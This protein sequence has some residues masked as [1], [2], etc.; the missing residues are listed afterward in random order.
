MKWGLLSRLALISVLIL[1]APAASLGGEIKYEALHRG[2]GY[3]LLPFDQVRI[4][5]ILTGFPFG[6]SIEINREILYLQE[7]DETVTAQGA[8][9]CGG[10]LWTLTAVPPDKVA[11]VNLKVSLSGLPRG[12][13][14]EAWSVHPQI[15]YSIA[16]PEFVDEPDREKQKREKIRD[17]NPARWL[18]LRQLLPLAKRSI[19]TIAVVDSRIELVPQFDHQPSEIVQKCPY[20]KYC[21]PVGR[22]HGTSVASVLFQ[23]LMSPPLGGHFKYAPEVDD[24]PLVR[25]VNLW[26]SYTRGRGSYSLCDLFVALRSTNAHIINYSGAPELSLIANWSSA[27]DTWNRCRQCYSEMDCMDAA[28]S[29]AS[30]CDDCRGGR[31]SLTPLAATGA[32]VRDAYQSLLDTEHFANRLV[33]VSSG[34]GERNHDCDTHYPHFRVTSPNLLVVGDDYDGKSAKSTGLRTVDL[35]ARV[36]GSKNT[37]EVARF[38]AKDSPRQGRWGTETGTTYA[39]PQVAAVAAMLWAVS[40]AD[41]P[42][43]KTI[44]HCLVDSTTPL[45]AARSRTCGGLDSLAA[46]GCMCAVEDWDQ[47]RR[48]LLRRITGRS[49]IQSEPRHHCGA[50][51][52]PGLRED[53]KMTESD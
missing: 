35:A 2:A 23:A 18:K 10:R 31:L 41:N 38:P 28:A 6:E 32:F 30:Y 1:L 12:S 46:I 33:V 36:H 52:K 34:N 15:T 42:S 27:R 16:D 17:G 4:N 25:G 44:A 40:V 20:S 21:D 39:A 13:I 14:Q 29:L 49:C 5:G 48:K 22:A 9:Y 45:T 19:P 11:A 3:P 51:S 26:K 53:R 50:T 24:T 8:R 7:P 43:A 37:L 47:A